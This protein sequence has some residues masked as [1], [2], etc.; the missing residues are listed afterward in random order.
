MNYAI[1]IYCDQPCC[2]DNEIWDTIGYN[3]AYIRDILEMFAYN[4]G[5]GDRQ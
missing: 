1:Q 2:H 5:F 4:R 3:S